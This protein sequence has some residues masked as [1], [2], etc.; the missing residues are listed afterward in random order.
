M[1]IRDS[2][3][4]MRNMIPTA[5]S[6]VVEAVAKLV[7]G[8]GLCYGTFVYAL[9]GYADTGAVFGRSA[10]DLALSLIHISPW[11]RTRP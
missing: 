9:Q 8:I 1:C 4:G 5:V 7:L 10:A 3:Q 6:Q 11:G 2:Y